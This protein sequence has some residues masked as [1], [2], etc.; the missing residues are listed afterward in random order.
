MAHEKGRPSGGNK[1]EPGTGIPNKVSTDN[2]K[3]DERLTDK[4]TR[5]DEHIGEGT[6]SGH[7]NRNEDKD[8]ATNIGGYRG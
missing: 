5:D 1:P 6:R 7:A 3:D 2:M 8:D 4:Y